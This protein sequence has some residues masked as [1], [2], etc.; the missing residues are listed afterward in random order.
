VSLEQSH[1]ATVCCHLANIA[2]LT[3]RTLNWEGT[4]EAITGDAEA[5]RLLD[6]PRRKGHELPVA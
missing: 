3:G 6:R 2:Y 5:S 1:Q 4:R